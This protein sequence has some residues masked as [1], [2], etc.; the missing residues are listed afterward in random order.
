MMLGWGS[1]LQISEWSQLMPIMI[2]FPTDAHDACLRSPILPV[3]AADAHA[4]WLV[5]VFRSGAPERFGLML[6]MLRC[7]AWFRLNSYGRELV[8]VG[9]S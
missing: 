1:I 3:A 4:A 5:F 7:V 2:G 9:P 8:L 6:I